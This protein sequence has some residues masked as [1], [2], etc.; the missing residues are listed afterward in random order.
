[1]A[2]VALGVEVSQVGVV[3]SVGEEPVAAGEVR[4]ITVT[5]ATC[6]DK[7]S[8]LEPSRKT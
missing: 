2:A 3:A 4:K 8:H 5:H 6:E 1:M 7:T